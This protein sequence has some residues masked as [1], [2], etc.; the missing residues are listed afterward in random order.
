MVNVIYSDSWLAKKILGNREAVTLCAFWPL[1][2]LIVI[3]PAYKNDVGLLAHELVHYR[4]FKSEWL[5]TIRML[6]SDK[7]R[8]SNEIKCYRV[9]LSSSENK[10]R[11]AELFAGYICNNY[12]LSADF[13][14]VKKA[15]LN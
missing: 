11:D 5:Y 4:Q 7:Y 10:A 3:S 14:A 13:E 15:L 12:R 2:V 6:C 9:Q 8:L 1:P